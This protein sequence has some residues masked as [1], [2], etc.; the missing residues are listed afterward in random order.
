MSTAF[1][2]WP[3]R[4]PN[5]VLHVSDYLVVIDTTA[6]MPER[7][8]AFERAWRWYGGAEPS[9]QEARAIR[10]E[11]EEGWKLARQTKKPRRT[12]AA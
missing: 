9:R 7:Q 1:T 10:A 6:P 12:K 4:I 2:F 8:A 3:A 11:W 5:H